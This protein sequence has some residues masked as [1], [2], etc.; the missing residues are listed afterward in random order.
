MNKNNTSGHTGVYWYSQRKKWVSE[1]FADGRKISLGYFK[2]K[3]EAIQARK[4]ANIEYGF[5]ENHGKT[6]CLPTP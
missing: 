1:I 6:T 5:H 4:Q 2:D 3:E